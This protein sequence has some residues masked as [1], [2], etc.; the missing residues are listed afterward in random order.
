MKRTVVLVC[1]TI[2]AIL[3]SGARNFAQDQPEQTAQPRRI[4][5]WTGTPEMALV[6]ARSGAT[7]P[8]STYSILPSKENGNK[9]LTGTIVGTSPF[10]SPRSGSVINAV[11]VPLIFDIEGT[12]FDPTT[13]NACDSGYSAITRFNLVGPAC[14][15]SQF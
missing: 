8:L 5:P 11:V 15:Q 2:G 9:K 14:P 7:I 13:P 4:Q 10:S 1:A 3:V 12:I 6:A